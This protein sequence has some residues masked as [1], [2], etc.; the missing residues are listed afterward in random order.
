MQAQ[1]KTREGELNQILQQ[2]EAL[3][4]SRNNMAEEIVSLSNQNESLEKYQRECEELRNK[5]IAL[6]NHHNLTLTLLGEKTEEC[7]ELKLDL[8]DVKDMFK[9]QTEEMLARIG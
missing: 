9:Q 6:N 3:K 5:V 4:R 7:E 2:I 8:Q 1:L